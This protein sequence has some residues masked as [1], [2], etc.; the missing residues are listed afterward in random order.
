MIKSSRYILSFLAF[1][2]IMALF[3][4]GAIPQW[5]SYHSFADKRILCNV[6]NFLNAF[7][8]TTFLVAGIFWLFKFNAAKKHKQFSSKDHFFYYTMAISLIFLF[9][10]SF[11]YHF[12]PDDTR[13]VWDRLPIASFFSLLFLQIMFELKIFKNTQLNFNFSVIYWLVS[14]ASVFIWY[15]SGDLRIY[16]FAQFYPLVSVLMLAIY[17]LFLKEYRTYSKLFFTLILGYGLA[18]VFESLDYETLIATHGLISGHTI[19]HI[20]AGITV[21]LYF[22][23][24]IIN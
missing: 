1:F 11:Y 3:F 10:G 15:Y 9:F 13:L 24:K 21:L 17:F 6:P 23:V 7:S 14:C 12:K 18:K 8:N 2:G 22:K 16:A 5:A 4:H 20:I 19:K